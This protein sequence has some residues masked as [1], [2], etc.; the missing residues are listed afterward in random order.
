[1]HRA[2]SKSDLTISALD[3]KTSRAQRFLER[4]QEMDQDLAEIKSRLLINASFCNACDKVS[5]RIAFLQSKLEAFRDKNS[6]APSDFIEILE[7]M[8]K[9][10]GTFYSDAEDKSV[11]R[12]QIDYVSGSLGKGVLYAEDAAGHRSDLLDYVNS[13]AVLD[14]G[15]E[16]LR[17]DK[18]LF[19]QYSNAQ[20][21]SLSKKLSLAYPRFEIHENHFTLLIE[22]ITSIHA[23]KETVPK[24]EMDTLIKNLMKLNERV[25]QCFDETAS[26][27]H[28]ELSL[29]YKP[30][31]HQDFSFT[32]VSHNHL[33]VDQSLIDDPAKE[34]RRKTLNNVLT[35]MAKTEE[36]FSKRVAA[37]AECHLFSALA[38]ENVITMDDLE[39]LGKGW[40]ELQL[41]SIQFHSQLTKKTET[42]SLISKYE[43]FLATFVPQYIDVQMEN[44]KTIMYHFMQS[45]KII[46]K[47]QFNPKGQQML[48]GFSAMNRLDIIDIW[49]MPIQRPPRYILLAK[50]VLKV[51]VPEGEAVHRRIDY[52]E[53]WVKAINFYA[54]DFSK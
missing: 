23:K 53:K 13:L 54:P 31:P 49:I 36:I 2:R 44:C 28:K 19:F 15:K 40:S 1:M 26:V 38:K 52:L 50:E 11:L 24:E 22:S 14:K 3:T 12:I 29:L 18:K 20:I 41:S 4:V 34:E 39:C 47:I 51:M 30:D 48:L 46:K 7:R 8:K 32:N 27:I 21:I 35:E 37:V 10:S 45:N 5:F 17:E 16:L 9:I 33:F 42:E 43:C 6:L 25:K